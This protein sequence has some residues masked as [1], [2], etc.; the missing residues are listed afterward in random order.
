MGAPT[1]MNFVDVL[2][3]LHLGWC[4]PHR[5]ELRELLAPNGVKNPCM[6]ASTNC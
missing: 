2:H 3:P 1:T 6:P 4:W 5:S